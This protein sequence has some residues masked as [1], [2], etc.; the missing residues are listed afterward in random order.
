MFLAYILSD[1]FYYVIVTFFGSCL[2]TESV[3]TVTTGPDTVPNICCYIYSNMLQAL[4]WLL[5][6]SGG[7]EWTYHYLLVFSGT[8]F[9]PANCI[10]FFFNQKRTIASLLAATEVLEWNW[11][12][13]LNLHLLHSL[14]L[15]LPLQF[16]IVIKNWYKH[17][18]KKSEFGQTIIMFVFVLLLL[19]MVP[20]KKI[21]NRIFASVTNLV[22]VTSIH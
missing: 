10:L 13:Q 19:L 22:D 5:P 14:T 16:P 20:M 9:L 8:Q 17:K 2:K 7:W 12:V 1:T 21:I 11:N 3:E 15:S 4:V 18:F 6:L